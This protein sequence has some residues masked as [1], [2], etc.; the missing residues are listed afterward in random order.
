MYYKSLI[1]VLQKKASYLADKGIT[2]IQG[3]NLEKYVS[4]KSLYEE[5]V[6]TLSQLTEKGVKA[7][8]KVVFQIDSN[9]TFLVFFWACL[10]GNII[11]VPVTFGGNLD[12][13]KKFIKIWDSFPRAYVVMENTLIDNCQEFSAHF[14]RKYKKRIIDT[15]SILENNREIVDID[16]SL[17][18][19]DVSGEDLAYIQFTSGS[20][21]DPKGVLL[22]HENLLTNIHSIM[23][24]ASLCGSDSTIGWMPLTHDMGLIGFH[25]TPLLTYINQYSMPTSLFIKRPDVWLKKVS[26]KGI[27]LLSSPNLGFKLSLNCRKIDKIENLDLSCVRLIF[28]GAEPI[29]HDICNKFLTKMERFNLNRNVMF[30]VYGMAEASLAVTFPRPGAQMRHTTLKRESVNL[31]EIVETSNETEHEGITFSDLG[32]PV[33][34]TF[35]KIVDKTGKELPENYVGFISIK[36]KNVTSGYYNNPKANKALIDKMGWLNTGDVGF[37]RGGR[38][39]FTGRASDVIYSGGRNAYAHDIEKILEESKLARPGRIAVAGIPNKGKQEDD[40]FVFIRYKKKDLK[41][42]FTLAE[43]IKEC[44]HL[45]RGLDISKIIPVYMIPKT[46]SGKIQRFKLVDN[47]LKGKYAEALQA[48]HKEQTAAQE[49]EIDRDWITIPQLDL[50]FANNDRL[51]VAVS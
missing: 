22:T 6:K 24:N 29:S 7:R 39:F 42:Y 8:D 36:G 1:E 34:D 23:N 37:I 15:Q 19:Q 17:V 25:L 47:Y 44:V 33:V 28:N 49:I 27:T 4:Y 20:T 32:F 43:K 11:P 21:G 18:A 48:I 10:L 5:A 51:E 38:L 30:T 12:C 31:G 2:F 9:E 45:Q 46:T 50:L 13:W 26:E 16:E 35:V 41:D 3:E 40:I 14:V